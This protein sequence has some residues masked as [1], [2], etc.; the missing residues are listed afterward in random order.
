MPCGVDPTKYTG[1]VTSPE[2]VEVRLD[3]EV[4]VDESGST[5][6]CVS[7]VG[8]LLPDR[9]AWWRPVSVPPEVGSASSP[10]PARDTPRPS[11]STA[12]VSRILIVV[13]AASGGDHS[14][15]ITRE[16]VKELPSPE[17]SS[18]ETINR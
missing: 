14:T 16:S 4:G 15:V 18:V 2:P 3:G 6:A 7:S 1:T 17:G 13:L 12:A 11:A 8:P 5:P 9:V 10:H